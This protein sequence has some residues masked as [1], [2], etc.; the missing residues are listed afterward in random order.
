MANQKLNISPQV[1]ARIGGVLYLFIILAGIFG[2]LIVR[3]KLI[4]EGNATATAQNISAANLLFRAGLVGDLL[5]HVCDV[6]LIVIFYVL[7]RPVS[8]VL[9]LLATFF[10]LVQTSV[11]AANKL[12]LLAVLVFLGDS[13]YLKAFEERQL[14]ALA[15]ASLSL[16]EYGFGVGLVFFGFRC[17]VV[18]YLIYRSEYFPKTLGVLQVIVGLSYLTNSFALF[19][20]PAL[21]DKLFPGVLLPAFIGEVAMCLWLIIK[22]VNLQKWPQ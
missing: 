17:L 12:T 1:Y 7:L 21:A 2:E 22:G 14:H 6:P 20:A 11:L 4:V 16:H 18:G 13:G 15:F 10:N 3:G 19:L 9:A 5:M 8:K